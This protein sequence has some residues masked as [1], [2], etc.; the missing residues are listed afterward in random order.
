MT[1]IEVQPE[2]IIN[3]VVMHVIQPGVIDLVGKAVARFEQLH[4][5]VYGVHRREGARYHLAVEALKW[6]PY[7]RL[8]E[9]IIEATEY[10]RDCDRQ[11]DYLERMDELRKVGGDPGLPF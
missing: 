4:P 2:D 1:D 11:L 3:E 7:D 10:Q 9:A 8:L 5:E 6:V